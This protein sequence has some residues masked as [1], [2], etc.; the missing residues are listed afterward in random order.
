MDV[1]L[2]AEL[3]GE[4]VGEG[5]E[6]LE[7]SGDPGLVSSSAGRADLGCSVL[8]SMCSILESIAVS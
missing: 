8:E 2:D 6:E 7:K 4:G 3:D 5:L 1:G